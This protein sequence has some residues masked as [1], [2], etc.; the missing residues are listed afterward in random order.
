MENKKH[1]IYQG[2]VYSFNQIINNNYYA[3]TKAT[4]EKKALSNIQYK[5]KLS[6]N[7]NIDAKITLKA[8]CLKQKS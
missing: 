4:S 3:E 8:S 7:L 6:H 1:F 5:Y 2:A